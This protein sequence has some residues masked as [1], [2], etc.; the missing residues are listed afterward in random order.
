MI[1]MENVQIK[2]SLLNLLIK[3]LPFISNFTI[4]VLRGKRASGHGLAVEMII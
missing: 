1:I 3:I 2:K 4:S